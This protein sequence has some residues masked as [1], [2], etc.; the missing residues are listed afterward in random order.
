VVVE[1]LGGKTEARPRRGRFGRSE[2]D[3]PVIRSP[4]VRLRSAAPASA[5]PCS[6]VNREA[7]RADNERLGAGRRG[8]KGE[9]HGIADVWRAAR[10]RTGYRRGRRGATVTWQ[11]SKM[12]VRES[13]Q[14][15][16]ITF[17]NK[18]ARTI[19]LRCS[20]VL[21]SSRTTA[22]G[23]LRPLEKRITQPANETTASQFSCRARLAS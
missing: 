16:T 12:R 22:H 23:R 9:D 14:P 8:D 4:H 13:L 21:D 18:I 1:A 5:A 6:G 3:H 17:M 2:G 11:N 7:L 15:L 10:G 19:T 20:S